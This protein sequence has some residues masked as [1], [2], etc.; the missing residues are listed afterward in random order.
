[1]IIGGVMGGDEAVVVAVVGMAVFGLWYLLLFGYS[2]AN[3]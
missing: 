3:R 1:M 2:I